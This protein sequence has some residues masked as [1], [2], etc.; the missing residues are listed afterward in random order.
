MQFR[1]DGDAAPRLSG[2]A[3]TAFIGAAIRMGEVERACRRI[4]I[5]PEGSHEPGALRCHANNGPAAAAAIAL[6]DG[7]VGTQGVEVDC[8]CKK[9]KIDAEH[10]RALASRKVSPPGA[11][12]ADGCDHAAVKLPWA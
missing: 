5:E 1:H 8:A 3:P 9:E 7:A 12:D 11:L 10:A 6:P 2:N 4:C